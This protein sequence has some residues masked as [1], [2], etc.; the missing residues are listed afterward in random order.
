MS[1]ELP[2]LDSPDAEG[3][4]LASEE[5]LAQYR[6]VR[7]TTV[8]LCDPLETEDY[9]VQSMPDA[10]P[11]K[12]HLAHTS[13]FFETFVIKPAH[14]GR[15]VSPGEY[16]FL[17]NSYYN[18]LGE[19]IA[20]NHR[21]LLSRPTVAE[22]LRYRSAVDRALVSLLESSD[23]AT[24]RRLAPL[25][26]LGCHHEQQH[27]ELILTDLK[28]L[29]GSNPVCP[30]Y[31][32]WV[33]TPV[34]AVPALRWLGCPG[35]LAEVGHDGPSFAFD[36]E[37]PRHT[38]YDP[39]YLLADRPVTNR[40]Y[41]GFIDDGGYDRPEFWLSDGWAAR[42]SQG[43]TA[44]L[45]WRKAAGERWNVFSLSGENPL[46][47][48]EP[49]CHVSYYEADAFARWAGA[50]LPGESEWERAA[51]GLPVL[52]NFLDSEQYH[53]RPFAAGPSSVSP[54]PHQFFGDVWEWTR[55]PYVPYPGYRPAS[56]ALGEYN[57]K[58]MC[59]QMVLRGGSC[60][61][62]RTH[63]RRTYRNF[64]PPDARWQFAGIRLALDEG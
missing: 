23:T 46:V 53:P 22:V 13:W 33:P 55:S 8:R 39:P 64:F 57:S 28:H 7:S 63:I 25:V 43:W 56:G 19:R 17:F 45:Y 37:S 36:N 3:G 47:E 60:A 50:R 24:V 2:E 6:L 44:P 20:R 11:V 35:G 32:E 61:T 14:D 31:R 52:G 59:N 27:Q 16:A 21:G 10:S 18:A 62:P 15:G 54:T 38:V 51:E 5:L 29:F 12:W 1:T 40:E 9:V 4:E 26:V 42:Q 58:F 49:V 48:S 41:L 34:S 30:A